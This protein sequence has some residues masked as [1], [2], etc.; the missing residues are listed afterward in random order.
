MPT[1]PNLLNQ[2]FLIQRCFFN[3]SYLIDA[4]PVPSADAAPKIYTFFTQNI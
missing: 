1:F 3:V 2:I 4:P